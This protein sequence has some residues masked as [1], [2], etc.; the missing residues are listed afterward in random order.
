LTACSPETRW[1]TPDVPD[2][3]RKPVE[4]PV[5]ERVTLRDLGLIVT[6]HVEA[7]EEANGRLTAI[8]EILADA[9]ARAAGDG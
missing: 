5:R 7:L 2:A 8:D 4:V 9:E 1:L 6:D 3:L